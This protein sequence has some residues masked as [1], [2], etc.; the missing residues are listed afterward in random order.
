MY[1]VSLSIEAAGAY[2]KVAVNPIFEVNG[3]LITSVNGHE[4]LRY[5]E[6]EI[7]SEG[8]VGVGK[9]LSP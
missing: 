9:C 1:T 8:G 3:K 6:A 2:K 7:G 5:L 4:Y